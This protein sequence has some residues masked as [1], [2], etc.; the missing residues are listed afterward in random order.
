MP[1][2]VKTKVKSISDR[3]DGSIV[4]VQVDAI[5]G[6]PNVVRELRARRTAIGTLAS[7]ENV[8]D[9]VMDISLDDIERLTETMSME[10]KGRGGFYERTEIKVRTQTIL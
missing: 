8:V 2:R 4:V 9:R 3:P 6:V 7:T 1:P 5:P 10:N